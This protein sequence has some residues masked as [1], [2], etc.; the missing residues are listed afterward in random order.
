S[1]KQLAWLI[2]ALVDE[3]LD[4]ARIRVADTE[5]RGEPPCDPRLMVRLL[6]YAYT[7]GVCSSRVIERRCVDDA[8]F[9]WLTAGAS[10]DYRA[11][12]RFRRRHVS[13]LGH[14]FVQ[15]LALCRATGVVRLGRVALYRTRV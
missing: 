11:I 13:A 4:L 7:T 14:L 10:P 6:F 12:A 5:A 9:R 3:H 15:A 2:A 8:A 1:A